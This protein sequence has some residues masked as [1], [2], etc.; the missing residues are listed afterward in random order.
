MIR[1]IDGC[2]TGWLELT[3]DTIE[4]PIEK[5]LGLFSLNA[6]KVSK[7]LIE[8]IACEEAFEELVSVDARP[9]ESNATMQSVGRRHQH[10][11]KLFRNL[12]QP[13]SLASLSMHLC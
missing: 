3:I 13:L 2:S 10:V 8:G 9:S 7:E 6:G 4:F 11:P 1:H 5:P 12:L